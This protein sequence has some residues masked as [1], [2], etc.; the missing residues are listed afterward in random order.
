M[1]PRVKKPSSKKNATHLQH[2]SKPSRSKSK[3]VRSRKK[4]KSAG[5]RQLRQKPSRKKLDLLLNVPR[6]RPRRPEKENYRDSWRL[7]MT[8]TIR[9]MMKDPKSQRPSSRR[10]HTEAKNC[11]KVERL[12]VRTCHPQLL[13]FWL[14]LRQSLRPL[15][16]L[17]CQ[18]RARIRKPRTLSS[19]VSVPRLVNPLRLPP[20]LCPLRPLQPNQ[21]THSTASPQRRKLQKLSLRPRLP[22]LARAPLVPAQKTTTGLLWARITKTSPP[23]KRVL[24][25]EVPATSRLFSSEPWARL[26]ICLLVLALLLARLHRQACHR[27]LLLR[28]HQCQ[29]RVPRLHPQCRV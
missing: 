23:M 7:L 21:T 3:L 22:Q 10:P 2:A 5:R 4:K 9:A 14:P 29:V 13:Q 26:E 8:R 16:I 18:L 19:S 12:S 6:S 27:R 28:H 25:Q 15:S 11:K 1:M 17:A 20:L 24:E